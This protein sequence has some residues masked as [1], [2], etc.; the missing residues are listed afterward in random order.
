MGRRC[1]RSRNETVFVAGSEDFAL[2]QLAQ[3]VDTWLRGHIRGM[4]G[5]DMQ[6]IEDELVVELKA[7]LK[8][9]FG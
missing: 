3:R 8:Q 2:H 6:D 4:Q 1:E 9:T 5:E 7:L